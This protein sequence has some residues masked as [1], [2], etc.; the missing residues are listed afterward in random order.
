MNDQL[1]RA[2]RNVARVWHVFGIEAVVDHMQLRLRPG[3]LFA[4]H[5]R[6]RF[7][8]GN[9]RTRIAEGALLQPRNPEAYLPRQKLRR[10][11]A[12]GIAEVGDPGN[13]LVGA[14]AKPRRDGAGRRIGGVDDKS[15]LRMVANDSVARGSGLARPDEATVPGKHHLADQ[16]LLPA[17]ERQPSLRTL[18]PNLAQ[19]IGNESRID[20]IFGL[21]RCGDDVAAIAHPLEIF[22]K[23]KRPHP[24]DLRRGREVIGNHDEMWFGVRHR[25]DCLVGERQQTS[26]IHLT[27]GRLQ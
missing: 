24:A 12:D 19:L 6:C 2:W 16:Q 18:V 11:P 9:D 1:V 27:R 13:F 20:S 23:A 26:R 17:F 8:V 10:S 7:H 15:L 3:K 22:A 21:R 4:P 25:F 14:N 5:G